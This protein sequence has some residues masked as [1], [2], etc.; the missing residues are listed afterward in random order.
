MIVISKTAVSIYVCVFWWIQKLTSLEIYLEVELVGYRIDM[1]LAVGRY[2]QTVLQND[3]LS[4]KDVLPFEVDDLYSIQ[5]WML[6]KSYNGY[7]GRM[8]NCY[9]SFVLFL[10]SSINFWRLPSLSPA[11][12]RWLLQQR[13]Q[14]RTI[15]KTTSPQPH[16]AKPSV[17]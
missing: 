13:R 1:Y 14:P 7:W 6:W 9:V 11:S 8:V 15:T 17:K 2:C 4:L 3:M 5:T 12:L 16:W 10:L